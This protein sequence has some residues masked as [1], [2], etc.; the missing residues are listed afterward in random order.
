MPRSIVT[1]SLAAAAV[2]GLFAAHAATAQPTKGRT[3]TTNYVY[4]ATGSHALTPEDQDHIRDVAAMMQRTPTFVATIVGKTNS[5]GSADF[6]EH[7]SQRRAE[8]VFEALVYANKVPEDRVRLRWTGEHLPVESAA[9]EE[10]DRTTGWLQLSLAMRDQHVVTDKYVARGRPSPLWRENRVLR[11]SCVL[12][13]C[14]IGAPLEKRQFA[15]LRNCF[16]LWAHPV[17]FAPPCAIERELKLGQLRTSV[18]PFVALTRR[19]SSSF[20]AALSSYRSLNSVPDLSHA[21]M[22]SLA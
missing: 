18:G 13:L 10:A 6:N 19:P 15:P 22:M 12:V 5:V 1:K 21:L 9:D 20:R 17:Q 11:D 8:A 14:A 2:M 4:F 7:L 3:S 16:F